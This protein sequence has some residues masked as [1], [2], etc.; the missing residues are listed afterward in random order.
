VAL[1][2]RKASCSEHDS[3]KV[4]EIAKH[5]QRKKMNSDE[6]RRIRKEKSDRRS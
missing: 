6:K 2:E 3:E 5:K 1:E 4:R